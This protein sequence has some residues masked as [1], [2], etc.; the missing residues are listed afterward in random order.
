M[1]LIRLILA[2]AGIGCSL[3]GAYLCWRLFIAWIE[4]GPSGWNAQYVL[5]MSARSSAA[6]GSFALSLALLLG[7]A[8]GELFPI[9]QFVTIVLMLVSLGCAVGFI[10]PILH[11]SFLWG[12]N[13]W[14]HGLAEAQWHF[15]S[16][17]FKG[18]PDMQYSLSLFFDR[19]KKPA[20]P[21]SQPEE[22][23]MASAEHVHHT[24]NYVE[25]VAKD[26][27]AMRT[28]YSEAFGWEY[29]DYGP[30]YTGI[31]GFGREMGGFRLG[32]ET[33]RGGPLPILYS[34]DLDKTVEAVRAAGGEI[35]TEPFDFP[36]GRRFHFLDPSGNELAVW[37][38]PLEK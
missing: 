38:F 16:S 3:L 36:G 13:R 31:K 22:R 8:S 5:G 23:V 35:V 32:D 26:M 9:S 19:I 37:G 25:F 28:F 6:C 18:K 2:L 34:D 33:T 11:Y 20:A 14:F 15:W 24:I 27:E 30:E 7:A 1:I 29:N 17:S 21:P 12:D 4:T 10:I